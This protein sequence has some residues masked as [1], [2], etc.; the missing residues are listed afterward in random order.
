MT[1]A[2]FCIIVP[3]NVYR[4][5]SSLRMNFECLVNC[6]GYAQHDPVAS[7]YGEDSGQSLVLVYGAGETAGKEYVDDVF[8]AGC[9]VGDPIIGAAW[10]YSLDFSRDRSLLPDGSSGLAFCEI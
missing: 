3:S 8:V 4:P 1:T 5:L 7:S 6:V 2:S 9:E 10:A